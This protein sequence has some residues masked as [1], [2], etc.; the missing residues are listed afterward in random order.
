MFKRYK[1]IIWWIIVFVALF[2]ILQ[3][4]SKYIFFYIEQT[5][6]FQF[7]W[8]YIRD[9]LFQHGGLVLLIGEFLTQFYLLNYAGAAISAAVIM[10]AGALTW[11]IMH[12]ISPSNNLITFPLLITVSLLFAAFDFNYNIAGAISLAFALWALLGYLKI[13]NAKLRVAYALFLMIALFLFAGP[14][15]IMFAGCVVIWEALTKRSS[16]Y[17]SFTVLLLSIAMSYFGIHHAL[18]SEVRYAFLPTNYFNS[19]ATLESNMY[20]LITPVAIITAYFSRSIRLLKNGE[21]MRPLLN[22]AIRSVQ[23]AI[24]ALLIW[25]GIGKYHQKEF[26]G[27]LELDH[28]AH[29]E[30]WDKI[31]ERAPTLHPNSLNLNNLNM[32]LAQRGEL[33]D[34]LF[35]FE[36][37]NTEGLIVKWDMTRHIATL[38]SDV[39]F[40]IG[41]ISMAQEMAFES[42]VVCSFSNARMLQRLVQTN[43]VYGYHTSAERYIRMLENSLFYRK[44]AKEHRRLLYD[45][46][47]IDADPL[48]GAKRTDLL[49]ESDSYLST[50]ISY[51]GLQRMVINNPVN[52]T[53]LEYLLAMS[54]LSNNLDVY[55]YLLETNFGSEALKVLPVCCQEAAIIVYGP[56]PEIINHYGISEQVV[57]DFD[58]FSTS[59]RLLSSKT[60]A[61]VLKE[62]FDNTFWYYNITFGKR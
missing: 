6:M 26:C 4:M 52:H 17:M 53:P 28:Y 13:E 32:A 22:I 51:E 7:S 16:W 60:A 50:S 11:R 19:G 62:Q 39:A 1:G 55:K 35:S 10:M 31:V 27:V 38:L 8:P 5:R 9:E 41:H 48:L 3:T 2:A 20:L 42:N 54:L 18:Y 21:S 45:D 37:I 43:L 23:I 57:A 25:L 58:K 40:T 49:S 30:Q 34:K 44:W 14:I 46:P 24:V 15:H 29:T 59:M 12:K 56:N 61:S 36:Q 47:A 33:L